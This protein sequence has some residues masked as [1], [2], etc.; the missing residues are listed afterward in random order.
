MKAAIIPSSAMTKYGRMD[1]KFFVGTIDKDR[2]KLSVEKAKEAVKNAKYRLKLAI[3][4][5][6]KESQRIDA[7]IA[8]GEV[9]PFTGENHDAT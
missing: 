8:S 1:A 6:E 7:L 2:G 9:I 3:R 5:Q 4:N